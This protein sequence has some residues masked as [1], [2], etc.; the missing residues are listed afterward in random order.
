M[1]SVKKETIL[2]FSLSNRSASVKEE[3]G[4]SILGTLLLYETNDVLPPSP[5]QEG[6]LWPSESSGPRPGASEVRGWTREG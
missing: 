1:F 2:C 3:C 4:S 6:H 5:H